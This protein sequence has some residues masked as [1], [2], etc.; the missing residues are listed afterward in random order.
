MLYL[1][2]SV[3]RFMDPSSLCLGVTPL[4]SAYIT[5][6]CLYDPVHGP[7]PQAHPA[8]LCLAYILHADHQS[9]LVWPYVYQCRAQ[10]RRSIHLFMLAHISKLCY[11]SRR[12]LLLLGSSPL[13]FLFLFVYLFCFLIVMLSLLS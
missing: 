13:L 9:S 5:M 8:S 2:W 1:P 3:P 10:S 4:C 11:G 6:F 7:H 12:N